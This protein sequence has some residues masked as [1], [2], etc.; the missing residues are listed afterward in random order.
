L[1][2]AF[3]KRSSKKPN[4]KKATLFDSAINSLVTTT[5]K[6]LPNHKT[7]NIV[8]TLLTGFIFGFSVSVGLGLST[9]ASLALGSM[10]AVGVFVSG[11]L[12]SY[13]VIQTVVLGLLA[14]L[15]QVAF[16]LTPD[17]R[18]EAG[19]FQVSYLIVILLNPLLSMVRKIKTATNSLALSGSV[20]FVASLM[21]AF[22]VQF[23]RSRMPSDALFALKFLYLG[24]DNAG[25]VAVLA[26]SIKSGY[27]PHVSQFG[28]FFNSLYLAGAGAI[29]WF[30]GGDNVGLLAPLTHYNMTL[31]FMAW[32]PI[33]SLIAL[34]VSGF[35]LKTP[36]AITLV[37]VMS[38]LLGLLFWP[39]ILLGHTSVISSGLMAMCL[40][41]V[42]LNRELSH[43]R[44][45]F[46]MVIIASLA[47]IVGT[48]W[49]PLMP[50]AG[51]T[52]LLTASV[53][54]Y[55]EYEKGRKTVVAVIVLF[56]LGLSAL[57]LPQVL[58]RSLNSTSYLQLAGGTRNP[59]LVF[60]FI[61]M[62]ILLLALWAE[63]NLRRKSEPRSRPGPPL[64]ALVIMTLVASNLY[65]LLTGHV[66]NSGTFGY[67]A[68]KYFLTSITFSLPVFWMVISHSIKGFEKLMLFG[69]A[70]ISAVLITVPDTRMV[71]AT[72][73]APYLTPFLSPDTASDIESAKSGVY[74]ALSQ[75]S[76]KKPEHLL[77]VADQGFPAPGQSE[78]MD[79]YMCTRWAQSITGNETG[80]AWRFVQIN[81]AS[82]ESLVDF[83]ELVSG[84]KV[85]IIRFA[86]DYDSENNLPEK[87]KT[88]WGGYVE[89]SWEVITVTN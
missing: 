31:L 46:F 56:F 71:P 58:D 80:S 76:E 50:F 9:L 89:D 86:T 70:M 66:A 72:I 64:F 53:L 1:L 61:W 21:F 12:V 47:F 54:L 45:M 59:G 8:L 48:T 75:A 32:I 10:V 27:S 60:P 84:S 44:P 30:A 67:G 69:L 40:I 63:F 73:V 88:W 41:S 13:L 26:Q 11:S 17:F 62:V 16:R 2:K 65:L 85:I 68:T 34:A 37:A 33:A 51:A 4:P 6:I 49:F 39:S 78:N 5:E 74:L 83:R 14:A 7:K 18:I 23:L 43:S 82:L 38:T 20:Q 35:K 79:A 52:V 15:S 19:V 3:E 77:C 57:L 87:S 22:L 25:V 55:V 24:E 28:E 81:R 36:V 42:T 29:S